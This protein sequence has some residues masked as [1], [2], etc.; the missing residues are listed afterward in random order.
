MTLFVAVISKTEEI[1]AL[2]VIV[3]LIMMMIKPKMMMLFIVKVMPKV[4]YFMIVFNRW[5]DA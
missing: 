3:M 4:N 1:V 5:S 2:K